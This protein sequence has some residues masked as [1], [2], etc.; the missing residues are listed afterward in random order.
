[1]R[2]ETDDGGCQR[3]HLSD[4]APFANGSRRWPRH[5]EKLKARDEATRAKP[6]NNVNTSHSSERSINANLP[7]RTD[8][9]LAGLSGPTPAACLDELLG[10]PMTARGV[11]SQGLSLLWRDH[12]EVGR[13]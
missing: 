10:A 1:M 7:R 4:S 8:D 2:A 12:A 11:G 3:V 9:R 5:A 13:P 6:A